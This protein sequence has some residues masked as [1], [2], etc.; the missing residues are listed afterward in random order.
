MGSIIGTNAPCIP[1]S[2]LPA[3][4][5]YLHTPTKLL[6]EKVP[7]RYIPVF[8]IEKRKIPRKCRK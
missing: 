1:A 7:P 4:D 5:L 3:A 2:S 6:D 8:D